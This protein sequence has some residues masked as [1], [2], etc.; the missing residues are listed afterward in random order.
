[1]YNRLLNMFTFLH[2]LVRTV[3]MYN[4]YIE[5]ELNSGLRVPVPDPTFLLNADSDPNPHQ[6]D[7]NLRSLI[8][9]NP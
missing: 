8:L 6:N 7:G 5:V 2:T 3:H 1:M 9:Y 4:L